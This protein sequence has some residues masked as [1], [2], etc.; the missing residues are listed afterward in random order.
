MCMCVYV[1][2]CRQLGLTLCNP[3]NC[4]PPA[5]SVHGIS[6]ARILESVAISPPGAL[7]DPRIK[8]KSLVSPALA[9]SFLT[10]SAT[11]EAHV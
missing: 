4:S 9:G 3:I 5:S 7:P 6:Q 1:C 11:S 8:P 10:I 2:A